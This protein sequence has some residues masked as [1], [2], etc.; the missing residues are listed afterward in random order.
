MRRAFRTPFLAACLALATAA[1]AAPAYAADTSAPVV[2]VT[3][4]GNGGRAYGVTHVGAD[5]TDDTGV[6][7]VELWVDGARVTTDTSAPYDFAWN[8][9]ALTVG[10][11]HSIELRAADTAGNIGKSAPV[12]ITIARRIA[13][14]SAVS[15]D[16]LFNNATYRS[17][18]LTRYDSMTVE[19][20]MKFDALEP[21][22]GVF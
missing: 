6:R 5:A 9:S 13:L 11:T 4:P 2:S 12:A 20:E 16:G 7:Q 19:N 3:H 15:S 22:K 17:T 21:Q 8:T 18:F 10:S 14:G 1:S